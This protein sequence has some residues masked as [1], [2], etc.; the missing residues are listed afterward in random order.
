MA[1]GANRNQPRTFDYLLR[2]LSLL[3]WTSVWRENH[4]ASKKGDLSVTLQEVEMLKDGGGP[5]SII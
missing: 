3:C 5:G 1:L 4:L 2:K